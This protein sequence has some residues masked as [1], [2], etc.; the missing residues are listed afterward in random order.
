M[1]YWNIGPTEVFKLE[2]GKIGDKMSRKKWKWRT[3]MAN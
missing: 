2:K 3:I 1:K